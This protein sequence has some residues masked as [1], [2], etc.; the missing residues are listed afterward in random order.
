MCQRR[1][2]FQRLAGLARLLLR[3]Q[4]SHGAHVVQPVGDLDHQHPRI[5]GHRE[6]HLA[7]GL[8]LGRG[9]QRHLVQLGDTVD[10]VAD[11]GAELLGQRLERVAG[12][13]DRVM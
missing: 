3:W 4:E 11:L 9:A 5:A 6:D 7:D 1:N 2:D 13:F 8:A 10:E 12:V